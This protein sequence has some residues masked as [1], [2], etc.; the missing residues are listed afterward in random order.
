MAERIGDRSPRFLAA[1]VP[2][3]VKNYIWKA[4]GFS[5]SLSAA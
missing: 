1:A 5:A 4:A 2:V 3:G